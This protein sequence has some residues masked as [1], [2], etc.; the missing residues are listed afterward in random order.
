MRDVDIRAWRRCSEPA[1]ENA[2]QRETSSRAPSTET[3]GRAMERAAGGRKLLVLA[4]VA[5]GKASREV[6]GSCSTLSLLRNFHRIVSVITGDK[7]CD[8]WRR[9]TRGGQ[10]AGNGRPRTSRR[11]L[12]E[13]HP[14]V[15]RL[16][17]F[18][19]HFGSH[20]SC[21]CGRF[22]MPPGASDRSPMS[23]EE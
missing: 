2:T 13:T 7:L 20:I 22:V 21:V 6:I 9:T 3:R 19:V 1:V 23:R 14:E 10:R 12:P 4:T 17:H 8:T 15:A 18:T 16:Q 11:R 5:H